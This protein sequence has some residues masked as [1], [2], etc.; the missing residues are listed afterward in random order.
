MRQLEALNAPNWDDSKPPTARPPDP[1]G[2]Q[3]FK[4]SKSIKPRSRRLAIIAGCAAIAA[5]GLV[6]FALR[7]HLMTRAAAETALTPSAEPKAVTPPPLQHLPATGPVQDNKSV[8]STLP[9]SDETHG[10]AARRPD[11]RNRPAPTGPRPQPRG[12][13]GRPAGPE[14]T[15]VTPPSPPVAAPEGTSSEATPLRVP[16]TKPKVQLERDNPWP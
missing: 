10:S 16:G 8:E 3:Q 12:P 7:S 4:S 5:M 2:S 6:I 15:A 1:T 9:A 11:V 14:E 13:N